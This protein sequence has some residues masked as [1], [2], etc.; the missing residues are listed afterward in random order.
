MWSS[1]GRVLQNGGK[2]KHFPWYNHLLLQ[3]KQNTFSYFAIVA[4][5]FRCHRPESGIGDEENLLLIMQT[6]D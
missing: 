3:V 5:I 1:Q 2:T 4:P 6:E